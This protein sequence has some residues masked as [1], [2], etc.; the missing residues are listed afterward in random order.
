[1][2]GEE[3]LSLKSKDILKFVAIGIGVGAT[4]GVAAGL[5]QG[6]GGPALGGVSGAV[7]SGILYTLWLRQKKQAQ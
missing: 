6:L 4:V 2:R 3:G 7:V 5:V 1:V